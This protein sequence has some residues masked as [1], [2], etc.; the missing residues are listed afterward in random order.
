MRGADSAP[1]STLAPEPPSHTN[2]HIDKY[3]IRHEQIERGMGHSRHMGAEICNIFQRETQVP[4][5]VR[6]GD[7]KGGKRVGGEMCC[8]TGL[9]YE[10]I[11]LASVVQ[12]LVFCKML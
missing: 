9:A 11:D 10:D 4:E 7:G 8:Q 3:Y 6:E 5:Q 1:T 12:K 2:A